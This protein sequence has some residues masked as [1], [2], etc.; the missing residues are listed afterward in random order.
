MKRSWL[1]AVL[2]AS[3]ALLG[4]R[5]PVVSERQA[6]LGPEQ[7]GVPHG[8]L[9]R[10]GQPCTLCHSASG[11]NNPEFSLAGTVYKSADSNEPLVGAVVQVIDKDGAQRYLTTNAVGTFYVTTSDWSPSFP[12]W[13]SVGYTCGDTAAT[14]VHADM[15]TQIFRATACADC[16]FDP[17][18]PSSAGHIYLSSTAAGLCP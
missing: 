11:G 9:H 10:P 8:P 15:Q 14:Y 5:N 4:C 13:T 17:S 6:A 12:L 2:A 7:P 18:G 3:I 16:H 1:I